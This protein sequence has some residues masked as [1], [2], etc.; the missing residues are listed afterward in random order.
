MTN[1]DKIAEALTDEERW[2][3]IEEMTCNMDSEER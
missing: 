3:I 2:E 1:Y